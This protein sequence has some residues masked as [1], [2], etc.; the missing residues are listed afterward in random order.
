VVVSAIKDLLTYLIGPSRA[1][2]R[3]RTAADN[4]TE[5]VTMDN[6]KFTYAGLFCGVSFLVGSMLT[7][8]PRA[9]EKVQSMMPS[10]TGTV[11]DGD[12][13]KDSV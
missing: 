3:W 11:Q 7:I 10:R 1:K 8:A 4:V 2:S 12:A 6:N 9:I 13:E 5:L